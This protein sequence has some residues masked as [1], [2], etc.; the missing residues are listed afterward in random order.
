MGVCRSRG[1]RGGQTPLRTESLLDKTPARR[2]YMDKWLWD[3][4]TRTKP[5]PDKISSGQNLSWTKPLPDKTS[6]G[7]N[8]SWTK[9]SGQ[10]LSCTKPLLDKPPKQNLSWTKHQDE[11]SRK[12]TLAGQDKILDKTSD[13]QIPGL[14]FTRTNSSRIGKNKPGQNPIRTKSHTD[15][16][17]NS[18][19]SPS[20]QNQPWTKLLPDTEPHFGQKPHL[21]QN[22]HWGKK[23]KEITLHSDENL[24]TSERERERDAGQVALLN[25]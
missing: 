17:P 22:T 8:L 9:P 5:L 6:P 20:D 14:N 13:G 15:K 10:N 7:Q 18:I 11:T 24:T 2:N 4:Q 1:Y 25:L 12:E 3:R 16:N 23:E 19:K 21:G